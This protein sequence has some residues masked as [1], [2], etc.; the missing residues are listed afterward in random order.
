MAVIAHYKLSVK[1]SSTRKMGSLTDFFLFFVLVGIK[2][3]R[4]HGFV[5]CRR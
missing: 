5:S 2:K 3:C 4:R 1:E